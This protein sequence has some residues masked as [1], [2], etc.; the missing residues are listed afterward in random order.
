M[1]MAEIGNKVRFKLLDGNFVFGELL[2][3]PAAT[4]DSW[5]IQSYNN[6]KKDVVLYIQQFQFM[7]VMEK[8]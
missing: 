5:I 6:G 4:G 7:A 1:M 3:M 8:G 2:S